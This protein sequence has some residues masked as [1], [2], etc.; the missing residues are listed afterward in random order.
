M[1]EAFLAEV[2][3]VKALGAPS[4]GDTA[5]V[6]S[7]ISLQKGNR[8]TLVLNLGAS[9]AAAVVLSLLQHNA[10]SAG[11]S[12]ALESNNPYYYKAGAATKF[13]KVEPTVADD[14][15][16]LSTQFAAAAGIIVV[17]VLGEQ[18]DNENG[19]SYFSV[20]IADTTAAKLISGVYYLHPMRRGAAYSEDL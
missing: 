19:F 10:A 12:K 6:G 13:T 1:F 8:C 7:R 16:D 14:Q 5:I 9:T 20:N 3:G 2:L 18:L 11:T 4:D 17:E 15:I